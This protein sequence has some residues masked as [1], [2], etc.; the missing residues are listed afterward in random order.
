MNSYPVIVLALALMLTACNNEP[1]FKAER[2]KQAAS[3]SPNADIVIGAAWPWTGHKGSLW[4]GIEL[5][6]EEI[7]ANGGVLHRQL[8]IVKEDDESSLAK[9]RLIAEQ[10]AENTDMVAVIG[11]NDSY[12]ALPAAAIYH[13]AGL[14]YLN[15]GSIDYQLNSHDYEQTFRSVPSNR[16]I[17]KHMAE[18]MAA[19]GYKRI[20]MY[21][22]KEKAY[23]DLA[24]YFEQRAIE[25]GLTI[26]DRRPYLPGNRDFSKVIHN[27]KELYQFDA[28]FLGAKMPEGAH[29]ID[30]MRKIGLNV[31]IITSLGLDTPQLIA[32]AGTAAEGVLVPEILSV[33]KNSPKKQHF[34]DSY[35]KKYHQTP[36]TSAALGYDSVFLLEQAIRQANS[37]VPEKI[38]IALHNTQKWLGVTGE[39]SFDDKG[40]IPDKKIGFK[41]VHGGQF[42]TVQ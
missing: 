13:S 16:N 39:F 8:R 38:A 17:A 36:S 28:L 3:A 32:I 1:D 26:I 25:L 42:E 14:V 29:I 4:Q 37:S 5:A 41:V 2:V 15:P 33:D 35:F 27:W 18:Y 31:P 12:I 34:D 30:Q 24:N 23:Q 21:Y 20:A 40:D 19:Q 10:F 7:N 22:V 9:G 6:T 11:H